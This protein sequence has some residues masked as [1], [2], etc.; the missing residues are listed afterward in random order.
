MAAVM[1]GC[2]VASANRRSYDSDTF[3]GSS[4]LFSLEADLIAETSLDEPFVTGDLDFSQAVLAEANYRAPCTCCKYGANVIRCMAEGTCR[5][6]LPS[7]P[8]P[9]STHRP[10]VN[11]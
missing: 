6:V 1:G 5:A 9:S 2:F 3:A 11:N 10:R 4:W 7:H 8:E